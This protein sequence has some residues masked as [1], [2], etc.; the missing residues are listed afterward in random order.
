MPIPKTR[1]EL[2]ELLLSSFSKL[3]RELDDAGPEVAQLRCVNDWTVKDL[4]AVRA[5]WT[6][7]VFDWIEAGRRGELPTVPAPGYAW[8]ETPRPR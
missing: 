5:W 8:K 3:R 1:Q 2:T 7:S 4:L 6:E